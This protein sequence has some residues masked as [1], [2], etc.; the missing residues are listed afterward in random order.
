[1][2]VLSFDLG[3]RNMAFALVEA[4]HTILKMGCIDLGSNSARNSSD[5]LLDTL[6]DPNAN[7][8]MADC[9]DEIVVELQPT[10]GPCKTLSFVLMTYFRMWD[11]LHHRPVRPFR[12][13]AAGFKL[14]YKPELLEQLNPESYNDR[15]DLAVKMAY[16]VLNQNRADFIEFFRGQNPK[17]K[18]DL[19]DAVIQ[20]CQ[21]I[22]S[23]DASSKRARKLRGKK[24]I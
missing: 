2:K 9:C 17:R 11:E 19:A 14:K 10:N 15:K 23:P 7:G 4:P 20:A 22:K 12:F 6:Q 5:V 8:W 24:T 1:M 13:M 21:H 18:T 3:T 16:E